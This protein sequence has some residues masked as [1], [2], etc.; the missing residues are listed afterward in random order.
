M[1]DSHLGLR[2]CQSFCS[3]VAGQGSTGQRRGE[4]CAAEAE[5]RVSEK[6]DEARHCV[7][8]TLITSTTIPHDR[9][10]PGAGPLDPTGRVAAL[11][12]CS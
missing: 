1:L 3:S 7:S 4:V 6:G 11:R 10:R 12:T 5:L 8:L 9:E 2:P